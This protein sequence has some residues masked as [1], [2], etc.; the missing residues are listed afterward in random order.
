MRKRAYR[1]AV[2]SAIE[3][4]VRFARGDTIT[5]GE[6]AAVRDA[7]LKFLTE[8]SNRQQEP[9]SS[10][11]WAARTAQ[12]AINVAA[13]LGSQDQFT[14]AVSV[15]GAKEVAARADALAV[16]HVATSDGAA[17]NEQRAYLQTLV[18]LNLGRFAELGSPINPASLGSL[19]GEE[20]PTSK[21]RIVAS[22]CVCLVAVIAVFLV[23]LLIK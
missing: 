15:E 13:G 19:R 23:W 1:R 11:A 5:E 8:Y 9:A 16:Y 21:S 6:A 18:N 2:A 22:V 7:A 14:R 12:E 3:V 10:A 17:I 4:A 20:Y